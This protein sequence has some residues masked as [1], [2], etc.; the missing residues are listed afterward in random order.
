[1]MKHTNAGPNRG[2]IVLRRSLAWTS[3]LLASLL[4]SV[5]AGG[6]AILID[7][8]AAGTTEARRGFLIPYAFHSDVFDTAFGLAAGRR[9]LLQEQTGVVLNLVAGTNGSLVGYLFGE[10][11]ELPWSDRLFL[12]PRIMAG[13]Y[14]EI[15]SFQD[16]NPGFLDERAGSNDSSED[17]FIRSE[18]T[19]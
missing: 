18:G 19:D 11:F 16:G 17:N 3:L 14:G 1:M 10:G 13:D 6:Q 12:S 8:D 7:K 5:A 9:G 2:G 4:T 15:D